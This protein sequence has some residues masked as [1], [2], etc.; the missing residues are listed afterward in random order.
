MEDIVRFLKPKAKPAILVEWI[1]SVSP[2]A[3]ADR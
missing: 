3:G 2:K 1:V